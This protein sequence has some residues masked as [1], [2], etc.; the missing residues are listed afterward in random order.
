MNSNEESRQAILQTLSCIPEGKVCTYGNIA[1]L[2]GQTG[3]ARYVGFIL[4]GLPN[5]AVLP[6]HRVINAKGRSS[7][8]DHSEKQQ[9]QF[10]KL[11]KEGI[12]V[13]NHSISLKKYLWLGH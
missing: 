4:K 6:W 1:S 10:A 9:I 13:T 8:P 12:E 7:F 2:A 3:K 11:T 5:N